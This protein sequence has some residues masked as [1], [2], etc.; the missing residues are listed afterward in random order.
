MSIAKQLFQLQE[1]D[2]ELVSVEQTLSQIASQL[3]E[4]QAVL[5]VQAE[6]AM[7]QQH[8]EELGQQQRSAEWE[9][10]DLVNRIATDE[11]KLYGGKIKNP[12]ELASLQHEVEGM[13]G[14]RNQLEGKAL[15]IMSQVDLA[16][17]GV[18]AKSSELKR[19][20]AE[21]RKQQQ[22]LSSEMERLKAIMSD[23][24]QKRQLLAAKIDPQVVERYGEL[25]RKKGAAVA[26][27]GQ[28]ICRGCRISLTT[29]EMQ[30][31]RGENLVQCNSCGRILFL[32]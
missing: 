23:L 11:E 7:E 25:R 32:P 4:S 14:R 28:G 3:G 1:V 5:G 17:A 6:L 18:A 20:E 2:T 26:K 16:K 15:E 21:W 19:L 22:E 9:I 24:Q 12:K 29:T 31:A 30:Q 13:K 27:V 8:L 10:D